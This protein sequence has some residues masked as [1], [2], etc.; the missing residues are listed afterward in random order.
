MR[1]G[2]WQTGIGQTLRSKTL[3]VF[4]YG[5]IGRVV[6]SYG[7]AF[8][9]RVRVWSSEPS[10]RRAAADGC[11]VAGSKTRTSRCSIPGIPSSSSTTSCARRTS[12]T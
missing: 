11:A 7:R 5:R 2:R 4:G 8:E 9:M 12:G 6:A 10:R 1:A 3:R